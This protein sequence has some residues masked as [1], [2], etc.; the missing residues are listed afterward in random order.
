MPFTRRQ[1]LAAAAG[2]TDRQDFIEAEPEHDDEDE[3]SWS[4]AVKAQA[5]AVADMPPENVAE[6]GRERSHRCRKPEPDHIPFTGEFGE[7]QR[8]QHGEEWSI[9]DRAAGPGERIGDEPGW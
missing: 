3:P 5:G 1:F 8:E 7:A 9:G 4:E 2:W 6:A